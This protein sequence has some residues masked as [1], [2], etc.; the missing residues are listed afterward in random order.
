[1]NCLRYNFLLLMHSA[2]TPSLPAA[3]RE[4]RLECVR[5]HV[6]VCELGVCVPARVCVYWG[7]VGRGGAEEVKA[8]V[9]GAGV[10]FCPQPVSV[11]VWLLFKKGAVLSFRKAA[12]FRI[13]CSQRC[14]HQ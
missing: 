8:G 6:C 3:C 1:M 7:G 11:H 4:E 2:L 14:R 10:D 12:A 5:L 13:I 9:G